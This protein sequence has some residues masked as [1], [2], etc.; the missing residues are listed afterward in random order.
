MASFVLRA[1]LVLS[2]TALLAACNEASPPP[3][4][5]D[6]SAAPQAAPVAAPAV[7]VALKEY[8]PTEAPAGGNCALDVVNGAAAPST[9]VAA[10]S[11][12][13]LSGWVTNAQNAASGDAQI[14]LTGSTRSYSGNLPTGGDRPDVATA[15][16]SEAARL[17]GFNATASL[18]GVEPGDYT[19]TIVQDAVS[20]VSCAL[21]KSVSVASGG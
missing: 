3:V 21:N 19:L 5:V 18:A 15:L 11:D 17:S 7:A 10:G 4:A 20:P 13:A 16:S 1:I 2:S 8:V 14:V 12:L 6:S 9:T